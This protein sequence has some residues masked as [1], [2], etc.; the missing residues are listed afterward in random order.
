[1]GDEAIP[2]AWHRFNEARVFGGITQR[3]PQPVDGRVNAGVKIYKGVGGP[4]PLAQFFARHHFPGSLQQHDQQF[5]W[6]PREFDSHTA[7]AEFA[8]A[9]VGLE[10]SKSHGRGPLGRFV[11]HGEG[12]RA[13]KSI[14][15][16]CKAGI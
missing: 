3:F 12:F 14:I 11:C 2:A 8:S 16:R 13:G 1:V 10:R 5:K 15:G 9:E 6:L 4:Q 7:L